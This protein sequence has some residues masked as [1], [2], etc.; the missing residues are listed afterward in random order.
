MEA[1]LFGL[2]LAPHFTDSFNVDVFPD[3]PGVASLLANEARARIAWALID[4][5][6]RSAGHLASCA[7][8]SAQSASRH[9][10]L[11]LEGRLLEVES[12]GRARHYRI[13][14]S[15]VA[16]M[17]ESMASLAAELAAD[18]SP[19]HNLPRERPTEFRQAR[20]CYDHFAG[21]FGVELLRGFLTARW[22]EPDRLEYRV[23]PVGERG[24]LDIGVNVQHVCQ[25]CRVLARPCADLS[26]RQSHLGGALGAA[27]VEACV[28][29]GYVLRTRQ[30]RIVT[31]T[32][33]GWQA[34]R[35]SGLIPVA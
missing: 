22:L 8:I 2:E 21:R 10:A 33:E 14:N 27:V 15:E 4:G 35:T 13:A 18:R 32:P 34:F 16:C 24:F 6:S 1:R 12:K 5:S 29:R 26:E 7:N 20:T 30:S 3:I 19:L 11:M 28:V 23:T 17:I 9:L 25:Q 31:I